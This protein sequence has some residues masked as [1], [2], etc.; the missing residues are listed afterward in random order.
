[1]QAIAIDFAYLYCQLAFVCYNVI[2]SVYS[3]LVAGKGAYSCQRIRWFS[4]N[5]KGNCD[6]KLLHGNMKHLSVIWQM[7]AQNE[8]DNSLTVSFSSFVLWYR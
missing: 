8:D 4:S 7:Q 1:M 6:L 5:H 2:L 3:S